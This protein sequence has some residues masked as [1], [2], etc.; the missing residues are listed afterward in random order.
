MMHL[1]TKKKV[2]NKNQ[3]YLGLGHIGPDE[4]ISKNTLCEF[5]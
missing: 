5:C 1:T 3:N 2:N 4:N